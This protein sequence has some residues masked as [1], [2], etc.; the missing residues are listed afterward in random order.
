MDYETTAYAAKRVLTNDCMGKDSI[1][2]VL[3]CIP[4]YV[5]Y[6]T[7]KRTVVKGGA[8][9][10]EKRTVVK[11]VAICFSNAWER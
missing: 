5:P 10:Q 8:I 3:S 11:C 2:A 9:E 7:R 4:K 6:E 1:K